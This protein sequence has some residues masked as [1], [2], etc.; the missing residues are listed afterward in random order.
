MGCRTVRCSWEGVPGDFCGV[1]GGCGS[2]DTGGVSAPTGG[3][4]TAP[5]TSRGVSG[6]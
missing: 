1:A 3:E 2:P 4:R 5:L 6:E